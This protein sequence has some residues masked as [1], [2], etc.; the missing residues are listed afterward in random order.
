MGVTVTNQQLC[1]SCACHRDCQGFQKLAELKDA[2]L[3]V[4]CHNKRTK[5]ARPDS[6]AEQADTSKNVFILHNT[7]D[8]KLKSSDLKSELE[9]KDVCCPR[10][11]KAYQHVQKL[12]QKVTSIDRKKVMGLCD[13][14][15][16]KAEKNNKTCS[17]CEEIVKKFISV[18]GQQKEDTKQFIKIWLSKMGVYFKEPI[19]F[20]Q[21]LLDEIAPGSK[22]TGES[23]DVNLDQ[24]ARKSSMPKREPEV[25]E[26]FISEAHK[27]DSESNID[28]NLHKRPKLVQLVDNNR[29]TVSSDISL[30]HKP[31]EGEV[32]VSKPV[33]IQSDATFVEPYSNV[34]EQIK[35]SLKEKE[36]PKSLGRYDDTLIDAK[37]AIKKRHDISLRQMT[38]TEKEL[39]SKRPQVNEIPKVAPWEKDYDSKYYGESETD[40]KIKKAYVIRSQESL[41]VKGIKYEAPKPSQ[42]DL[43]DRHGLGKHGDHKIKKATQDFDS[44]TQALTDEDVLQTIN[45]RVKSK[46]RVLKHKTGHKKSLG[47]K[48]TAEDITKTQFS[49]FFPKVPQKEKKPEI[50]IHSSH[51]IELTQEKFRLQA[52]KED[53][54]RRMREERKKRAQTQKEISAMTGGKMARHEYERD[55]DR[56]KD[57]KFTKAKAMEEMETRKISGT[58]QTKDKKVEELE[59]IK[60][61]V[62]VELEH[63]YG[64]DEQ[65][66][67]TKRD[68]GFKP[69]QVGRTDE[70][71]EKRKRDGQSKF[72]TDKLS[73]KAKKDI[74][75]KPDKKFAIG[76]GDEKSKKD[77]K[78]RPEER[79]VS[80]KGSEKA[81]RDTKSKPGEKFATG[82]V[83]EKA[84]K[85]IK[86]K[87]GEK[88]ATGEVGE[89][90][91][92]DI[93]LKPGEKIATGEV[94]EKATKDTKSKPGEKFTIGEVGEKATKEV[95]SKPEE[96]DVSDKVSAKAK[97]DIKE[98]KDQLGG[99][100]EKDVKIKKDTIK[101]KPEQGKLDESLGK[102]EKG[103]KSTPEKPVKTD[104]ATQTKK[105]FLK[106]SEAK[107]EG[108][109]SKE[110]G[111][112][113]IKKGTK[114][115]ELK[116]KDELKIKK[117]IKQKAGEKDSTL[118]ET[119][120]KDLKHKSGKRSKTDVA[121]AKDETEVKSKQDQKLQTEEADVLKKDGTSKS[122][123]EQAKIDALTRKQLEKQEQEEK[124][125]REKEKK[126]DQERLKLVEQLHKDKASAKVQAAKDAA[127]EQTKMEAQEP[128]KKKGKK[129]ATSKK[130]EDDT[131]GS[132]SDVEV[133]QKSLKADKS[134]DTQKQLTKKELLKIAQEEQLEAKKAKAAAADAAQFRKLQEQLVK[135]KDKERLKRL[136]VNAIFGRGKSEG[137]RKISKTIKKRVL[138]PFNVWKSVR[139]KPGM[140]PSQRR[141]PKNLDPLLMKAHR[142]HQITGQMCPS[143]I[144]CCDSELEIEFES[145]LNELKRREKHIII[146]E[147]IYK[148]KQIVEKE[149][150]EPKNVPMLFQAGFNDEKIQAITDKV[151]PEDNL[152]PESAKRRI[153]PTS[154]KRSIKSFDTDP[155]RGIIRYALSDRT[156]IDKGWTMLPTEK[157][158]RKMNVYRMRPAHPEFDWFEHNKNKRLMTYDSGER[159]AEFDDNGRG[160]WYY[161][162]GR[163][164]LDYYDAQET[165]AQQ[166]FVIYSSG[167]PD[168]R[169]RSHPI[170][171][172]ATFDYLGNG[173]VFDHAGKIR[174]K[175]NQTEGVVLDRGIG[176]V[177]HWKWHTLNDPPVLQQVMIDTQMAHK[178]PEIVQLGSIADTRLRPD[179]EEMLA[180]EFDNF[181]K[182]KSKKLSQKFKPFQIKMKALKINEH[183]SLKV[184]DQATI[185]LIYRD[186]STN[187]KL[188]IGMILDHQE[189][190]DTD[191]AE[192]GE[193]SNSLERFPART[194]SLAGLQRSVA[195]A[196]R[197]ERQRAER[198]RRLRR[199]EPH[200]SVDNLTAA[201]APPLRPP[202]LTV[203][204]SSSGVEYCNC[205]KPANN[206][207]Y[208]TRLL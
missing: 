30:F 131:K 17:T 96:K 194:D 197:Y 43:R 172:L 41:S 179:N 40:I 202:L 124:L 87:P 54:K 140:T 102:V 67:K 92:K 117:D 114:T 93:K 158:V 121:D 120:K 126:E 60:R 108:E 190:V 74:K 83:G 89:K 36:E 59:K 192:V 112:E 143:C 86:S 142:R 48:R 161:R 15:R 94:G 105:D 111:V 56:S 157:V 8:V 100:D 195:Y 123:K 29:P 50:D 24:L 139:I 191:T 129:G 168:E 63:K 159:L 2:G 182:E 107:R 6:T 113:T 204:G 104:E 145:Y 189:I 71:S 184:L 88:I 115:G 154:S 153:A 171:I 180:I 188:N 118:Q 42:K 136:D 25:Q 55:L 198:D 3:V 22:D 51:L 18:K 203:N 162:N 150:K 72:E 101:A 149:H 13:H 79:D 163:L 53:K 175:Y 38:Q 33:F 135:E 85:D 31:H 75:S 146:G 193:V 134:I 81:K 98:R 127:K 34:N 103:L 61:D 35:S 173:V 27:S 73:E 196:Q 10:C 174:L 170:T 58:V 166:R 99:I 178:D 122:D 57:E 141:L 47:P 138:K 133:L 46:H 91:T 39:P 128:G 177:S 183:F 32:E 9:R 65:S 205:R 147:R 97:K 187:L 155:G 132:L 80:G 167:E 20:D 119:I 70:I 90:A 28:T 169:G 52:E 156:F 62:K 185:Y 66:G 165:N 7:K 125:K 16:K 12:I 76:E 21:S 95:K 137:K 26:M 45:D 82:E 164:A 144:L 181:I 206:L 199:P 201:L 130:L 1:P 19:K 44:S 106:I 151:A 4:Y 78:L 11:R 109:T 23:H 152:D 200:A 14:C 64:I 116:E 49:F 207:Y 110:Q 148:N 77:V 176:P 160:R 186:G 5:D 69:E 84:K 37:E 208:N 68:L